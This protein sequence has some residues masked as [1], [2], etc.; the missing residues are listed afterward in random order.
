M[1]SKFVLLKGEHWHSLY[2]EVYRPSSYAPDCC[3]VLCTDVEIHHP[4][5]TLHIDTS[6]RVFVQSSDVVMVKEFS[7]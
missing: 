3:E 7:T 1:M 4:L 2:P 6:N 5:V